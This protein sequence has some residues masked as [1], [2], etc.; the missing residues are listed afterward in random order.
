MPTATEDTKQGVSSWDDLP[1]A[2]KQGPGVS[3]WNDL[4]QATT[5]KAA[6]PAPAKVNS[7][8][9]LPNEPQPGP[10]GYAQSFAASGQQRLP[11]QEP[12]V[13]H[14]QNVHNLA[15]K[16]GTAEAALDSIKA[17]NT[18]P[19][20]GQDVINYFQQ[21][22]QTAPPDQQHA[23]LQVENDYRAKANAQGEPTP[24]VPEGWK[25]TIF[26]TPV[27]GGQAGQQAPSGINQIAAGISGLTGLNVSGPSN[28]TNIPW[29]RGH[30]D[31]LL[32]QGKITDQEWQQ[33]DQ[34]LKELNEEMSRPGGPLAG[35]TGLGTT[36][37]SGAAAAQAWQN[38]QSRIKEIIPDYQQLAQQQAT[39]R[40]TA[41]AEVKG[42]T[43]APITTAMEAGRPVL[44]QGP[45]AT[46]YSVNQAAQTANTAQLRQGQGLTPEAQA[47]IKAETLGAG[48]PYLT[49][50]EL[51]QHGWAP[52]I[53][54]PGS[55]EQTLGEVE[56]L[57]GQMI[58]QAPLEK[59]AM[60]G[61]GKLAYPAKYLAGGSL[62][63]GKFLNDT[64]PEWLETTK[65]GRAVTH[66]IP[67]LPR[68][69]A[70]FDFLTNTVE[71]LIQ[72]PS[73]PAGWDRL[74]MDLALGVGLPLALR[75]PGVLAKAIGYYGRGAANLMR[76]AAEEPP[77]P[78]LNWLG[79]RTSGPMNMWGRRA[80]SEAMPAGT[81]SAFSPLPQLAGKAGVGYL[82]GAGAGAPFARHDNVQD[83]LQDVNQN[84]IYGALFGL[85]PKGMP[86]DFRGGPADKFFRYVGP[87]IKTLTPE[88]TL[89]LL[90]V[91]DPMVPGAEHPLM[92]ATR[93]AIDSMDKSRAQSAI[94]IQHMARKMG[95]EYWVLP[96][97][98]ANEISDFR[99]TIG[100]T[101]G[102]F[103][104]SGVQDPYNPGGRTQIIVP[105]SRFDYSGF[106]EGVGHPVW[107]VL[108]PEDKQTVRDFLSQDPNFDKD[109]F[110]RNYV[111]Q[112]TGGQGPQPAG[113]GD[114][115][116]DAQV[117][118]DPAA[119]AKARAWG[120]LTQENA[121]G[122]AAVEH[123]GSVFS[124]D[125][126]ENWLKA[127]P[128]WRQKLS[129]TIVHAAQKIGIPMVSSDA[130]GPLGVNKNMTLAIAMAPYLRA[131][132]R[133]ELTP[134]VRAEGQ[135]PP[136]QIKLP[137]QEP[138]AGGAAPSPAPQPKGPPP[139]PAEEAVRQRAYEISQQPEAGTP[140]QN[141]LRAEKELS[142][143][144]PAAPGPK[145]APP[146]ER[147]A[148]I[149]ALQKLKIPK[150]EAVSLVSAVSGASANELAAN[151]LARRQKL[152]EAPAVTIPA[153]GHAPDSPEAH[154]A[155]MEL[156]RQGLQPGEAQA[157]SE[158]RKPVA[159]PTNQAFMPEGGGAK[160]TAPLPVVPHPARDQRQNQ[161]QVQEAPQEQ[162]SPQSGHKMVGIVAS[163]FGETDN[164]ER[165]GYTEAGW[166]RGAW[167]DNLAGENNHGVALPESILRHLGYTGQRNYGQLF[168]DNYV[169]RI[170]NPR[171]G[172][173]V[174]D[175]LK[176]I[177]PGARTG[178]SLDMLWGTRAALGL[179]VNFK[180]GLNF[181]VVDK[182]TGDVV[183]QPTGHEVAEGGGSPGRGRED[184]GISEVRSGGVPVVGGQHAEEYQG[185]GSLAYES[186]QKAPEAPGTGVPE[187]ELQKFAQQV[188]QPSAA[189]GYQGGG[190]QSLPPAV[191]DISPEANMYF[192]GPQAAA[193]YPRMAQAP[194]APG[195]QVA[196]MPARGPKQL[197]GRYGETEEELLPLGST[198]NNGPV[199]NER[200]KPYLTNSP[201]DLKKAME[202]HA[203]ALSEDDLRVQKM[204][205]GYFKGEYFQ[206]GDK[207]HQHV[208][209]NTPDT[210]KKVLD[211]AQE[212]IA[213]REPMH[214]TYASAPRTGLGEEAP[215]TKTR[216]IE[217][218]LSSPQARMLKQTSAQLAGHTFIPTAVGLKPAGKKG[219]QHEGYV[220]GVSM[221]AAAN[222]HWHLN[223]AIEEAGQKS[224]Y[225]NLDNKF[226]NDMEGYV[227]NLNAG[228]RGT[229]KSLQPSTKA[230][231][232]KVDRN[233][234][235]YRLKPEEAEYMNVL[236]NNQAARAKR[237]GALRELAAKG[238]TLF[239]PEGETNP[240]RH[241]LDLREARIREQQAAAHPENPK[242]QERLK[243]RWSE[244][245]LE[246][247]IR[248]FKAGL[249]HAIHGSHEEMPEA[250]RP[251]EEFKGMAEVMQ[252]K[253]PAGR[254]DV[255]ISVAFM[256]GRRKASGEPEEPPP[257]AYM[258]GTPLGKGDN[259]ERITHAAIRT[260]DKIYT[261]R[262][263][264][265]LMKE[266]PSALGWNEEDEGYL[267]SLG[268]FLNRQEAHHLARQANQL[269][270]REEQYTRMGGGKPR[271]LW[272]EDV[273]GLQQGEAPSYM[274]MAGRK[275]TG[276]QKAK[277][278][279]R[280][281]ETPIPG[282]EEKPKERFEI[283]DQALKLKP[284]PKGSPHDTML[285]HQYHKT[286]GEPMPLEDA[287]DHP[288]LFENYPQLRKTK[289]TMDRN[290]RAEGYYEHPYSTDAGEAA[291]DEIHIKEPE[292]R[293]TMVHE[294]QHAIQH[295]EDFPRGTS[296]EEMHEKL[297]GMDST[298]LEGVRKAAAEQHPMLNRQEWLAKEITEGGWKNP[299]SKTWANANYKDYVA[300]VNRSRGAWTDHRMRQIGA[301]LYLRA[302]GE[303]E[304]KTAGRRA[305]SEA[306]AKETPQAALAMEQEMAQQ[307]YPMPREMGEN[308]PPYMEPSFMPGLGKK[309][310]AQEKLEKPANWDEQ[311]EHVR[312]AYLEKKVAQTLA[313]QYRGKET[314]ELVVQRHDDGRIKYDPQGKPIYQKHDYDIVNSP[315]LKNKALDKIGL[316]ENAKEQEDTIDSNQHTHLNQV[317]RRR[318]SAMRQA[319]AVTTMG[320]RIADSYMSI[321]D[322]P[323]IAAGKG[324]YSR[325]RQ[326]LAE[327][328]GEGPEPGK[329]SAEHEL[330]AQLLGAT[331]A[332]TPVK[333]NFIQ[334]LDALE[335][336]RSGAFDRHRE[337]YLEA[338]H[339]LRQGGKDALVAHMKALGI[340]L[341]EINS[342]GE[343][344]GNVE[345]HDTDA[346]A[347]ANWIHHHNIL[348]RQKLQPGQTIGSKYNAN[349]M[350]VLRA[351]AGTWLHE[352]QAPKTPNFAGNLTG[353][354]LEAT[355]DVWAA[356]HLQRLGYEGLN[357]GKPWRAQG[358]AEPGVSA[359]DF[360]F[361]QDAM[362]HAAQEI[363]RRTGEQ[364]NPDDLQ[365]ILWF[366]EK[367][368]YGAKGWTR[369]AG[370]EKSSFDDVAD[371]AF[372]KSG[373]PMTSEDLRNHYEKIKL[374][375]QALVY[376]SHPKE[377]MRK[378][379]IPYMEKHGI[380]QHHLEAARR[381]AAEPEEEEEGDDVQEF[382]EGGEVQPAKDQLPLPPRY[383]EDLPEDYGHGEIFH[384]PKPSPPP[385]PRPTPPGPPIP[386]APSYPAAK[387]FPQGAGPNPNYVPDSLKAAPI[388]KAKPWTF[389]KD[390][391]EV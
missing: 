276:F 17:G 322:I 201:E 297:H 60:M 330:F 193:G 116:T 15:T 114:L 154:A 336:Y 343:K 205:D 65:M 345:D 243:K 145:A 329:A 197:G 190:G 78:E 255:P 388:E 344:G 225:P 208:L 118:E 317:E 126:P 186:Q 332:K 19:E 175:P 68:G 379:M 280:V 88:N 123:F 91:D 189:A 365:A 188:E 50:E 372:P 337:K 358:L 142:G 375:E 121:L 22:Y 79:Q 56:K 341:Y 127:S 224:P 24:A 306:F 209:A 285:E 238:G 130:N 256:P 245:T 171:N 163:E 195:A 157:V 263:H 326:K 216:Q 360:A 249:I 182:K 266:I 289:I 242:L 180:G 66:A 124:G 333:N 29:L 334:A 89:P 292:D 204:P 223:R 377:F 272:S 342:K 295:I 178:A 284:A 281:F 4:P 36:A 73:D 129:T 84:G 49:P 59:Y 120:N 119:A 183:Y 211:A 75:T 85:L 214:V 279:G 244:D 269:E 2:S 235:A 353:R 321:K 47:R 48:A 144:P 6:E 219:D 112:F 27:T 298:V 81:G 327:A 291:G 240:L 21:Q 168:N 302:P 176:D 16:F 250:I 303:I 31:Q 87:D 148:A 102:V 106:H 14:L 275:A 363:T 261:G 252:R 86:D 167:G 122:E 236:I 131:M 264:I 77:L 383:E 58:L 220:Q 90:S 357:K 267:T 152:K 196:Y 184:T 137:G 246:P 43:G 318:L 80:I 41:A 34:A 304:A 248:T 70:G 307:R 3:S 98:V 54:A 40:E 348:P 270:P 355:I 37:Q 95:M 237:A 202:A 39:E 206:K 99:G 218:Q 227:A 352:V 164:P 76:V 369:G 13:E 115:P 373:K 331:S 203:G 97:K 64:L 12:E 260:P 366:A 44:Q 18:T 309:A 338:Y 179:P 161:T 169:V 305:T 294:I 72:N 362:R 299:P 55:V 376:E 200:V 53:Q 71:H 108:A 11:N 104:P 181:E 30:L 135:A 268:R 132:A 7:W 46:L 69:Y 273:K 239:T 367:H 254:P 313:N 271:P 160:G 61:L 151:A 277:E 371:L 52:G 386:V 149:K 74:R 262:N 296:A 155:Q 20:M 290:M 192:Y 136:G 312:Q 174:E 177:G 109:Q 247:T 26:E 215:T 228:Y 185:P 241:V 231:P 35:Q 361:S 158:G 314:H 234:V 28:L 147:D 173:V 286:W 107:H 278:T 62:N 253:L 339:K 356:R 359:L 229:G 387:R 8:D 150:K 5:V 287:I 251:G 166:N 350:A 51:A 226:F 370:A 33:K 274:P 93:Q 221:N 199:A 288:E 117:R 391:Q 23:L 340:P 67:G 96:D 153:T 110:V 111:G 368:H 323:S 140:E 172:N 265:D 346:D 128:S 335:Q 283:P 325:M 213:N 38:Y 159:G 83:F 141:W 212:S 45:E 257:P 382:Q 125:T 347:M 187:A 113:I 198:A 328:L 42:Q 308:Q 381:A 324:W 194:A 10:D 300:A 191:Q 207:L 378:R 258:P 230:Y 133:G 380:E 384:G 146:E 310:V 385:A 349:S 105:V 315:L 101:Q 57:A 9:D 232:V 82:A 217:Y 165:G 32:Q 351:I 210:E 170:H 138:P 139:A 233:H 374:A 282:P 354:T 259:P 94:A 319:S 389:G 92:D 1:Q 316:S 63:V 156:K 143:Q 134:Q 100:N 293:G 364:M 320:N 390:V 222:N 301:A 162:E 311:P 103:D 25:P